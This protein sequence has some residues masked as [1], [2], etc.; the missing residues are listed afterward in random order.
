MNDKGT[1]A[2]AHGSGPALSS[3][4]APPTRYAHGFTLI[5][6]LLAMTILAGV[7]TVIYTSFS[8]ASQSVE[9]AE[10]TRDETDLARTLLAKISQ[11]IEN[12]YCAGSTKIFYGKKEEVDSKDGKYRH[13]SLTLTTLT[14]WRKPDSKETELLVVGYFFKQK[15]DN[16][17]YVLMRREKRDLTD[18]SLPLDG[19][20]EYEIADQV[21]ELRLRYLNASSWTDDL[22]SA[23]SCSPPK[24][25]EISLVLLSG[26]QYMTEARAL[27]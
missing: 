10:K 24:A 27:P 23:A 13:D 12:T 26:K 5:E 14:N 25:V 19:G 22:G 16:S 7:V 11:D 18:S 3:R 21:N 2:R 4:S 17:G 9:R 1:G 20:V 8:T 6:V 15:P